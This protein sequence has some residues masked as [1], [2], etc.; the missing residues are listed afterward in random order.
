MNPLSRNRVGNFSTICS[1]LVFSISGLCRCDNNQQPIR[2]EHASSQQ[3]KVTLKLPVWITARRDISG[4][5]EIQ[6]A[7]DYKCHCLISHLHLWV[8]GVWCCCHGILKRVGQHSAALRV[9]WEYFDDKLSILWDYNADFL[10]SK[11]VQM[12]HFLQ[13][14]ISRGV[15][16]NSTCMHFGSA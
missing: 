1:I 9:F 11:T 12:L 16:L 14:F 7:N 8:P 2:W 13:R 5:N 10:I 6:L 4:L 15:L 3:G